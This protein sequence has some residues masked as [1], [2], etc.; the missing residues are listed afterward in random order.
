MY[1][2]FTNLSLFTRECLNYF[3]VGQI[4]KNQNHDNVS[5]GSTGSASKPHGQVK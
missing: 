1:L 3:I 4:I 2:Y 5:S